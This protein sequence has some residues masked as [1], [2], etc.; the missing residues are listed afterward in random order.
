MTV[1]SVVLSKEQVVV[2]VSPGISN[3]AESCSTWKSKLNSPSYM[4]SF[5]P[6][7]RFTIDFRCRP[8]LCMCGQL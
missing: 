4:V 6:P 1:P 5:M 7:A 8:S 3:T 2:T